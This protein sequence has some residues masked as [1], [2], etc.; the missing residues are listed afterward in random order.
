MRL[1]QVRNGLGLE[2]TVSAD[3][4][5]DLSRLSYRGGNY[6]YFAP[7]GYVS[8]AYYDPLPVESGFLKSFTAGFLTTCGLDSVG[9]PSEDAGE[10]LPLHGS[11]ANTPVEHIWW[12][13][14]ENAI[15]IR[16]ITND[17]SMFDRK[18]LLERCYTCSTTENTLVLHDRVVNQ[19]DQPYPVEILYHMNMG[20]PLLSEQSLLLINSNEVIPRNEH[21]GEGLDQWQTMLPPTP[22]FE[23]QCYYH[24]FAGDAMAAI[25]SPILDSG[26]VIRYDPENLPF[27]TQW[28]MMGQRDYVL[29]L[30]PGNAHPDGRARMRADGALTILPPGESVEYE[31]GL[32]ILKSR[33]DYEALREESRVC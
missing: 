30:E 17:S 16:S 9:A 20:Y 1:L 27:F 33:S 22:R 26:L 15:V 12:T 21:A 31:V 11:I 5:A 25:Y 8:P 4:N 32:E 19:G 23:E 7:C 24:R 6:G 2:F 14:D 29:G 10:R 18:L 3:R 28:K 13:Q